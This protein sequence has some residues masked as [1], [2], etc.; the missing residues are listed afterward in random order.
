MSPET[1]EWFSKNWS[2]LTSAP[3]VFVT[4]AVV[5]VGIGYIFGTWFKN[6]EISILERRIAEYEKKVGTPDEAKSKIDHLEGELAGLNKVLGVTVGTI[7]KPLTP[8]E[9]ADLSLKLTQ[10]PKHRVQLMYQNQLGKPLA[11]TLNEAF[12]KAGWSDQVKYTDGGGTHF[13]II[14]GPGASKAK[15][16]KDAIESTTKLRISL[17]K[18]NEDWGGDLVYLF[19]GINA[20]DSN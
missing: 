10:I 17:D 11:D 20:P 14:A 8:Q 2:V 16:L 6:G 12:V 3:W 9:I 5:A 13:G 15:V 4:F 19:V 18:P 1:V 7:W